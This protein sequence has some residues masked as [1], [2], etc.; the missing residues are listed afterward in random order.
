VLTELVLIPLPAG[1]EP[2]V[3]LPVILPGVDE[4]KVILVLAGE[5][6]TLILRLLILT[7]VGMLRA[8]LLVVVELGL[9]VLDGVLLV[10]S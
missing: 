9:E 7:V 1:A 3:V 6:V 10:L 2:F 4:C 5:G 8:L